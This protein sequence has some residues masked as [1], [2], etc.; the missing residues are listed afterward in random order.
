MSKNDIIIELYETSFVD[1]YVRKLLRN[2]GNIDVS[3]AIQHC[4]LQ[5]VELNEEKLF[6]FYNKRGIK[7]VISFVSGL[8]HRQCLSKNS[9]LYYTHIKHSCESVLKKRMCYEQWGEAEGWQK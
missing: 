5:I 8:I 4:W 2:R 9:T 6:C 3:E 1:N 7:G